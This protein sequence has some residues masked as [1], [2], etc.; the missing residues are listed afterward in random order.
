MEIFD[1]KLRTSF[2]VVVLMIVPLIVAIVSMD[3]IRCEKVKLEDNEFKILK[4]ATLVLFK[5]EV[6]LI[7][8]IEF[9]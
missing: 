6:I 4:E 2:L 7:C 9:C 8:F 5:V 3:L 1:G